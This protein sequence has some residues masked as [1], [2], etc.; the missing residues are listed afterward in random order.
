MVL[1]GNVIAYNYNPSNFDTS[2]LNVF[3]STE[4]IHEAI[5]SLIYSRETSAVVIARMRLGAGSSDNTAFREW[6]RVATLICNPINNACSW[7]SR[8]P[9]RK[10]FKGIAV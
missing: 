7:N 9:H 5:P 1:P 2:A 8:I 10:V 6:N 3:N 4:D